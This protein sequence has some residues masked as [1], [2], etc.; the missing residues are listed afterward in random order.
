[1]GHPARGRV[2]GRHLRKTTV[3]SGSSEFGERTRRQTK[4]VISGI[5]LL[6]SELF[7]SRS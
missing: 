2:V 5:G 3:C 7:L 6:L 1:M 4:V